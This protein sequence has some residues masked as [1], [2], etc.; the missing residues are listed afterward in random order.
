MKSTVNRLVDAVEPSKRPTSVRFKV[1]TNLAVYELAL[2][3]GLEKSPSSN[4]AGDELESSAVWLI[5]SNGAYSAAKIFA[6]IVHK[7]SSDNPNQIK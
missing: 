4:G 1:R 3:H 2:K 7:G 5:H 6:K